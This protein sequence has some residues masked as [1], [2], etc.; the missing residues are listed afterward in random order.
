MAWQVSPS[1]FHQTNFLFLKFSLMHC[2]ALRDP[3]LFDYYF[4]K[5][6]LFVCG[7][8]M[9]LCFLIYISSLLGL[10]DWRPSHPLNFASCLCLACWVACHTWHTPSQIL[11]YIY[12]KRWEHVSHALGHFPPIY[13]VFIH[14]LGVKSWFND[15][16]KTVFVL[17]FVVVTSSW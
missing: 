5:L 1:Q 13:L 11:V 14:F 2:G 15:T 4:H 8:L 12:I 7:P 17:I 9:S 16:E 6:T 10:G 3:F